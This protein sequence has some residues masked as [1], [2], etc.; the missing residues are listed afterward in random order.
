VA[1]SK[2]DP[3]EPADYESMSRRS[4]NRMQLTAPLGAAE[5]RIGGDASC[6]FAHRRRS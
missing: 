2:A 1:F 4:N 5:G 6:A 3:G